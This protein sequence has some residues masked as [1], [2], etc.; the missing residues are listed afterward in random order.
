MGITTST[1]EGYYGLSLTLGGG[2]VKLLDMVFAYTGFAN[3][4]V[5]TA[6]RLPT[7]DQKAGYR[8]VN[9]VSVL[10]IDDSE[11][12]RHLRVQLSQVRDGLACRVCLSDH[13]HSLRQRGPRADLRPGQPAQARSTGGSQDRYHQR[14][15]GQLDDRLHAR[16]GDRRLGRQRQQ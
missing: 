2:E 6:S 10:R 14:L 12:T 7:Q 8:G 9:P 1:R 4:G 5:S 11:G 3:G 15:E 16:S 13:G